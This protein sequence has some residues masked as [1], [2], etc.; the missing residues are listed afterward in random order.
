[1]VDRRDIFV[2]YR[3]Y[4]SVAIFLLCT[5]LLFTVALKY[6][7]ALRNFR[8]LKDYQSSKSAL[9]SVKDDLKQRYESWKSSPQKPASENILFEETFEGKNVLS[10]V[11]SLQT[12]STYGFKVVNN[13]VYRG[14]RSGRFELRDSDPMIHR[15]TRTELFVIDRITN[16]ERWYS[17]AAFFPSD[18]YANDSSNELISQWHQDGSPPISLRIADGRFY[19]RVLHDSGEGGWKKID[20]APVAKDV[21]HEFVFH[22]IHSEG[23][24]A[25]IEVWHNGK[26][27]IK[28]RGR[29]HFEEKDMP[30]WKVGIYKAKW[31]KSTTDTNIRICY[32]DDIRV[33]DENAAFPEM[34]SSNSSYHYMGT[35]DSKE[36]ENK[37]E[38]HEGETLPGISYSE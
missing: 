22:I 37:P 7:S 38:K 5:L 26:Q 36:I 27:L 10:K 9:Y 18:G 19:L 25:L 31:N 29:N 17:F 13:P 12:S 16:K 8:Q 23:K 14:T 11:V 28:Y 32:F 4:K 6:K 3:M 24:D 33:G 21:W 30:Y 2:L 20:L 15:G 34:T 35:D 1:M